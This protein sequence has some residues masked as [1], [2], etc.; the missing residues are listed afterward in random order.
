[1]AASSPG[2]NKR[3]SMD[4]SPNDSKSS[5]DDSLLCKILDLDDLEEQS[6]Q[7]KWPAAAA[8]AAAAGGGGGGSSL[9][10]G[11]PFF[12]FSPPSLT[13]F[14]Y[15][16][17]PLPFASPPCS[18]GINPPLVV[19]PRQRVRTFDR[20]EDFQQTTMNLGAS[21]YPETQ[22]NPSAAS[23]RSV[24]SARFYV[25]P[26]ATEQ[27][28]E[29][30]LPRNVR[31][32]DKPQQGQSLHVAEIASFAVN[33]E[34]TSHA[35]FQNWGR[36]APSRGAPSF[37]SGIVT[38]SGRIEL[39]LS[40]YLRLT[41]RDVLA[42][43]WIPQL[44]GKK[45]V[46]TT[47]GQPFAL[48]HPMDH[49]SAYRRLSSKY[50]FSA[51]QCDPEAFPGLPGRVFLK[52][53]PEWTPN[54]QFY[55]KSEY[56]RVND[57][58]RCNI[59]GS[60]AVPVF[61]RSTG[62]CVAVVELVMSSEEMNYS[63][64]MES[65]LHA[66]Q[67]V[68]L[69]STERQSYLPLQIHT[70]RRQTVLSEISEVLV[71]VCETHNLPLAQTWV[72]CCMTASPAYKIARDRNLGDFGS[73]GVNRIGLC[74]GDGPYC[75]IDLNVE[76]FRH[77]CSEHCLEKEQGVPGKAFVSNQPFFSSDVKEYSKAEYPLG[78]YARVY[79]LA[80]AVAIRLRSVHTADDDYVLEFFLPQMCLDS[81]EQQFMLNAI[82]MTMQRVCRS[83]H[84]VTVEEL[85][86]GAGCIQHRSDVLGLHV[87]LDHNDGDVTRMHF[88]NDNANQSFPVRNEV[89]QREENCPEKPAFKM[90]SDE[91]KWK[92]LPVHD[93][94]EPVTLAG[95]EHGISYQ[96]AVPKASGSHMN[97]LPS[98][99]NLTAC[100]QE[101]PRNR[102]R[103][104]RKHGTME[105]T[106]S[107]NVL[108]Q[109]FTGNLKDA[110]KSIGGMQVCNFC[111]LWFGLGES[112]LC[113]LSLFLYERLL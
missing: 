56:L 50:L 25:P 12:S 103:L 92:S 18:P 23:N 10:F 7:E 43:V 75:V 104:D 70:E 48:R 30:R 73:Y 57:A 20:V 107:L 63:S 49:F 55:K 58:E 67:E 29:G 86:D 5:L 72:P 47:N 14:A 96:K 59:R 108:Q 82:S 34:A 44:I 16:R 65:L 71:A 6:M 76:G 102:R 99:Q 90:Q 13:H 32:L 80:A 28:P 45:S 2:S 53:T 31:I 22:A 42:Q 74:T 77:A 111:I 91:A 113:V 95:R 61:E 97:K 39:A 4:W 110:A 27:K 9:D 8:A 17:P 64:E 24:P 106:I 40:H 93:F 19:D 54:V 21:I 1:M 11:Q 26:L 85:K 94:N 51:D 46:L 60:L 88:D 38:F 101:T 83:L 79:Q 33:S 100:G 112:F 69:Y 62:N 36:H 89:R 87:S 15:Q 52:K 35:H 81:A 41:Q 98:L 109:Y 105:K 78:H 3:T 66:F 37:C 68:N 84:T